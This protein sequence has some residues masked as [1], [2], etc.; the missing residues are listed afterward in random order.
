MLLS[1]QRWKGILGKSKNMG[2]RRGMAD[3]LSEHNLLSPTRERTHIFG[4]SDT[5]FIINNVK[6]QGSQLVLPKRV[7]HWDVLR[8]EDITSASLG[9]VWLTQEPIR[10]LIIGTGPTQVFSPSLLALSRA[11]LS[12]GLSLDIMSTPHAIGTFNSLNLEGRDVAAALL[13][14][15]PVSPR[16]Q[17]YDPLSLPGNDS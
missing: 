16:L 1:I 12:S 10:Y 17:S 4:Y 5:G 8:P 7:Y 6:V 2:E 14:I 3:A 11:F 15:S 9:L 13:S